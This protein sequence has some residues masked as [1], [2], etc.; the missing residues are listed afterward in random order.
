MNRGMGRLRELEG[1]FR[2]GKVGGLTDGEPVDRFVRA[3][4]E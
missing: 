2:D 1:L 3:G 4:P